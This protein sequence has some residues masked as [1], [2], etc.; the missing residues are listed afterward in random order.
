MYTVVYL[1]AII[2][3]DEKFDGK[4]TAIDGKSLFRE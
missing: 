3:F 4:G 2:Q 1:G